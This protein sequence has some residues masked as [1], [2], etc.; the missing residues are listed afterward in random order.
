M[1]AVGVSVG[2]TDGESVGIVDGSYV[3]DEV[4]DRDGS[5]ATTVGVSVVETSGY[6]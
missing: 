2:S 4:G 1:T 6:L 3:G 5:P